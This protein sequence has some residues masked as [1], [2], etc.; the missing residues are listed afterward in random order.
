MLAKPRFRWLPMPYHS[1]LLFVTWLLLNNTLAPGHILLGAF[2]AWG[3]PM[4]TAGLSKPQPALHKPLH[5]LRYGLMV[6]K[7]I[8]TANVEVA[9]QVMGPLDK[10]H[11][12]LIA[13]PLDL[14]GELPI[15]LL[16]STCS[17]TP[18]TVSAEVSACRKFLYLHVLS[19]KDEAELIATIKQR[20]EAP[21][22]EI[23]SC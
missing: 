9:I 20:Y 2:L 8:I 4:L 16:A 12:A 11:P 23:F 1:M 13:V 21:L 17:L 10:L 18:G 5:T 19:L 7:D 14:E 3:I 6:L 22:M 15:T